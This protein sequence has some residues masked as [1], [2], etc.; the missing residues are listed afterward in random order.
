VRAPLTQDDV[1]QLV[2]SARSAEKHR[3]AA[4]QQEANQPHPADADATPAFLLFSAGEQLPTS[5]MDSSGPS[6]AL[7]R[8]GSIT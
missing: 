2:M 4:A 1:D 3:T 5:C 7:R 8:A 6:L